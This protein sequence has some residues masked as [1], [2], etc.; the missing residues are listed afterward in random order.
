VP[1]DEATLD[2][3]PEK[4]ESIGRRPV[5]AGGPECQSGSR[6][7]GSRVGTQQAQG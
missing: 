1:I 5:T 2:D 7:H 3:L 6:K 4:Q